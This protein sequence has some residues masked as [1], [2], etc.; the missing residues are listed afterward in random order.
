MRGR[1]AAI[2]VMAWVYLGCSGED[3][4]PLDP[5]S[6]DP[7]PEGPELSTALASR[8]FGWPAEQF[9]LENAATTQIGLTAGDLAV[10]FALKDLEGNP[11]RLSRLLA[12]KPVLL[13]TGSYT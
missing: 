9:T 12:T 3:V 2:A 13:V 7:P 10:D 8:C 5:G 11:H 4:A 6:V 1:V